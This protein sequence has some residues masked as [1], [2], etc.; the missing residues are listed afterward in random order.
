MKKLIF[1]M[2]LIVNLMVASGQQIPI[3]IS[4]Q[5]VARNNQGE[6]LKNKSLDVKFS[7]L[8][9][10]ANGEIVW[11]ELHTAA[12]N[13]F[14]LFTLTIGTEIKQI[15]TAS[16]FSDIPWS[17]GPF[18]LHV[19]VKFDN[20][21]ID[22]GTTQMLAVPYAL[23]ALRSGSSATGSQ[24]L[25]LNTTDKTLD[26]SNS[27]GSIK[28]SDLTSLMQVDKDSTN[29]IQTIT[30]EKDSKILKLNRNGG[31]VDFSSFTDGDSDP[32]NELQTLDFKDNY[33]SLSKNGGSFL[34]PQPNL[35]L[36]KSQLTLKV[37]TISQGSYSID[38][39]STNEIQHLTYSGKYIKLD[40]S[41]GSV[42]DAD[43]S[44]TNEL[45]TTSTF[46]GDK[47]HITEAGTDHQID[48]SA[49]KKIPWVGFSCSY[50]SFG[51]LNMAASSEFSIPWTKDF[52]DSNNFS[53]NKFV[54][55]SSGVY[56]FSI[57]LLFSN[58]SDNLDLNIYN[59]TTKIKT[60]QELG[61]KS[62][63]TSFLLKLNIGDIIE[64]KVANRSLSSAY[65]INQAVFTGYRVH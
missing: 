19:E 52:D 20:S 12:T 28:V 31:Q 61:T 45:I 47:L 41:G 13:E 32:T 6:E 48:I 40:K 15:G 2:I 60:F 39:D 21:F 58:S 62:F 26:L 29:E 4:F 46:D 17:S 64:I 16:S 57:S 50:F 7:I 8:K 55:P 38:T 59:L 9:G 44:K 24:Q 25:S 37:G 53:N 30:Y 36:E 23:Y 54:I 51:T 63:S 10:N 43:T 27:G 33:V 1:V 56:S 3:G 5:A 14:G 18:Y 22:M 49:L 11:Q 65:N 34:L 35:L 42:Y